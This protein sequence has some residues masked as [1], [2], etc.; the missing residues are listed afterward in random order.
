MFQEETNRFALNEEIKQVTVI[1]EGI[2]ATDASIKYR[3]IAVIW[4]VED[5]HECAS[6][7]N[8][9]WSRNWKK[10]VVLASEV[11]IVLNLVETVM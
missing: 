4:K 11:E 1:K 8:I 10:N 6:I 5:A 2:A 3:S 9:V 7:S